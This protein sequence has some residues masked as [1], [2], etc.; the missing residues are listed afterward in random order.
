MTT[1][2][3]LLSVIDHVT[4]TVTRTP[5][6]VSGEYQG[7]RIE[8]ELDTQGVFHW[9]SESFGS[10]S[11]AAGRIITTVTGAST[12]DRS[13]LSMNGWKF[14]SVTMPDGEKVTLADLRAQVRE[15]TPST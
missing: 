13:Y 15:T 7:H 3:D 14:W 6:K 8:A 5:L 12:P 9:R 11:V 4:K 10:P 2:L 1:H